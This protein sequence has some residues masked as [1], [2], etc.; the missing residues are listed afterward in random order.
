MAE[1]KKEKEAKIQTTL[2]SEVTDSTAVVEMLI[3]DAPD[4][5]DSRQFVHLRSPIPCDPVPRVSIVQI[6]ALRHAKGLIDAQIRGLQ[7][8]LN[9]NDVDIP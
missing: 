7:S 6:A 3:S 8:A 1:T 5:D 2:I 4:T 9:R